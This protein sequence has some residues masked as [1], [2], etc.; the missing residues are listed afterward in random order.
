MTF[1]SLSSLT[2]TTL[3][4]LFS[5]HLLNAMF[6]HMYGV[7]VQ[8]LTKMRCTNPDYIAIGDALDDGS[9]PVVATNDVMI[10]LAESQVYVVS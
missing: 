8:H 5:L 1:A 7:Q 9:Y 3:Q 2:K 6:G 4:K 10:L